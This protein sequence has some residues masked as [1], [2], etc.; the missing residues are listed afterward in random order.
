MDIRFVSSLTPED[1]AQV[2]TAICE[3]VG[4]LL[5]PFS[6]AFTL[7]IVTTDGQVFQCHGGLGPPETGA[8]QPRQGHITAY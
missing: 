5:T 2:A 7:R 1:E 3:G 6:L 4:R 8:G